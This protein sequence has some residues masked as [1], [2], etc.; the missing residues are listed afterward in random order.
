MTNSKNVLHTYVYVDMHMC[1]YVTNV[2]LMY[3]CV[4]YTYLNNIYHVKLHVLPIY[5]TSLSQTPFYKIGLAS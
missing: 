5:L 3:M 4:E 2:R 1:I